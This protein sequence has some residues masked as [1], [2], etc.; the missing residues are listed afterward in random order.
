MVERG[1]LE[2][3]CGYCGHRGFESHPLRHYPSF[4]SV[5]RDDRVV[6]GA[7]LEIVC[8]ATPYRGFESLSLRHIFVAWGSS[9]VGRALGSQ[10]GGRGFDS[11]LL[12]HVS[13]HREQR[14]RARRGD[15][16]SLY[17]QSAIAGPNS[18]REVSHSEIQPTTS[19]DEGQILR[20][21]RFPNPVRT[22][23]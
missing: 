11:H 20:N 10:S 8:R 5:W 19:G 9:S 17:S 4:F 13:S 14:G 15:S 18:H 23:R 6:E 12:H 21:G 2:N 3:R 1:G 16:G 22:G 7:R